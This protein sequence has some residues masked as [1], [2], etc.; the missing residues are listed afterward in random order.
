M[1]YYAIQ[2]IIIYCNTGLTDLG[3]LVMYKHVILK[4][5]TVLIM[6]NIIDVFV[7]Y[8][9]DVFICKYDKHANY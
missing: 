4:L 2:T 3:S 9:F 7:C 1:E 6:N 5:M 8:R